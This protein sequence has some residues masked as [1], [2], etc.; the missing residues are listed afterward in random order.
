M[1]QVK[2]K[3][4]LDVFS[5]LPDYNFVWKFETN[6]SESELPRNVLIRSW[7]PISDILANPKV[8]A[9]FFHGGLLTTQEAI[10]RAVPM[11]IMPFALDQQQVCY[12][13]VI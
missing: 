1:P 2:R 13:N 11:I 9:I 4:F 10:W 12:V 5:N 3:H 6:I 7:L 8:K